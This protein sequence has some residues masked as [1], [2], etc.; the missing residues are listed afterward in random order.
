MQSSLLPGPRPDACL[1]RWPVSSYPAASA[2]RTPITE[3][4]AK[5]HDDHNRDEVYDAPVAVSHA[6]QPRKPVH[7]IPEVP[8]YAPQPSTIHTCFPRQ[9]QVR[10]PAKGG[11]PERRNLLSCIQ[12]KTMFLE[13]LVQMTPQLA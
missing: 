5:E 10:V 12:A 13:R 2:W 7:I 8:E 3:F 1:S 6:L 9:R 4:Y 11:V